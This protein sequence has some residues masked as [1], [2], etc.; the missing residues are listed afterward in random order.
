MTTE[1]A[2]RQ[3]ALSQVFSEQPDNDEALTSF[4]TMA[5][6]E[7]QD[8]IDNARDNV[9]AKLEML[10]NRGSRLMGIVPA[11]TVFPQIVR[12]L[13]SGKQPGQAVRFK[14]E[15]IDSMTKAQLLVALNVVLTLKP[16]AISVIHGQMLGINNASELTIKDLANA[17]K[18]GSNTLYVGIPIMNVS[19]ANPL[20]RGDLFRKEFD[21]FRNANS[22]E[23]D[24]MKTI[25]TQIR[26]IT[27]AEL[28][29]MPNAGEAFQGGDG[30]GGRQGTGEAV[31]L[32]RG[33]IPADGNQGS[34]GAL[35]SPTP[36]N[37]TRKADKYVPPALRPPTNTIIEPSGGGGAGNTVGSQHRPVVVNATTGVR[38]QDV[39]LPGTGSFT[40]VGSGR[41]FNKYRATTNGY[42]PVSDIN[43]DGVLIP[44]GQLGQANSRLKFFNLINKNSEVEAIAQRRK[45]VMNGQQY[46]GFAYINKQR[47]ASMANRGLNTNAPGLPPTAVMRANKLQSPT[48]KVIQKREVG[49]VVRGLVNTVAQNIA[50][51][52]P[53]VGQPVAIWKAWAV[54]NN[55]PEP[56]TKKSLMDR[57]T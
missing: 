50:R 10:R 9:A 55:I 37:T 11:F 20:L 44:S 19:D 2:D 48:A 41:T 47:E 3:T 54:K 13:L 32:P 6:L 39:P 1:Q 40:F 56:H 17:V 14:E 26:E 45:D 15:M 35:A 57:Y 34:S 27:L 25:A 53:G 29:A 30:L 36:K 43:A 38:I 22:Q 18:E 23:L 7:R 24:D 16:D 46:R 52:R 4:A 33:G 31:P 5:G 51:D 28:N 49:S 8:A 21:S 12:A 42:E